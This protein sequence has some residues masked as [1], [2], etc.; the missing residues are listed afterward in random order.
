MDCNRLAEFERELT[1]ARTS[2]GH[3]RAGARGAKLGRPLKLT[4]HQRK[5]AQCRLHVAETTREI[6][7]SYNVHNS[8]NS[9]LAS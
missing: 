3:A 1:N 4:P 2:E 6:A 5:E 9:R 7:L 8:T